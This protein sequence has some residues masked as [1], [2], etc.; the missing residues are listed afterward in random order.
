M[1]RREF[2][3]HLDAALQSLSAK[4]RT[5]ALN[6]FEEMI[7]DKAADQGRSEED[8]IADLGP[9]E[10]IA[11][12]V[13]SSMPAAGS[14][15]QPPANNAPA[16]AA[17]AQSIPG[18]GGATGKRVEM[19]AD[20]VRNVILRVMDCPLIIRR[21][22]DTQL[23]L[24]YTETEDLRFECSL[25]DGELRLIQQSRV[26][27]G[28]F[29]WRIWARRTDMTIE[30]TV[31]AD[32]ASSLDAQTSN[33]SVRAEDISFWGD[34]RLQNANGRIQCKGLQARSVELATSNA[35]IRAEHILSQQGMDLRTSNASITAESL[36]AAQA[37][38]LR[39]S[40]GHVEARQVQGNQISLRSSNGALQ[41]GGLEAPDIT[42][43]TSNGR[44][45]GGVT[46]KPADYTVTASTVNASTSLK[47][48][49]A[50]GPRRLEVRT[51]NAN[52]QVHF[53]GE[54]VASSNG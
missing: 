18:E 34:L 7:A 43:V 23:T 25:E 15:A 26:R 40:N 19:C 5:D 27:Y 30:L 46:G 45:E 16:R 12:S 8:V 31:P 20:Q 13:L 47:N 21:G 48:H 37:I 32:I 2:L 28:L 52:I 42:L 44:I 9:V 10:E 39:T 36:R 3:D 4:D 50:G 41:F 24:R 22:D 17:V 54:A 33:S 14:E 38:T 51:L 29:G 6:F 49:P 11:K 35:S 1:N 53:E